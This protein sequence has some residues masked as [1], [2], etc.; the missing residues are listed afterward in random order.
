MDDLWQVAKPSWYVISHL[1]QLN[2]AI[3]P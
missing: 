2:P 1:G 3:P